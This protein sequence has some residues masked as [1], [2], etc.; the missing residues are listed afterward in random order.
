MAGPRTQKQIA[1]KYKGNLAYF[2]KPHF[3]RRLKFLVSL[4]AVLIGAAAIIWFQEH[5]SDAFYS[6][7]PISQ[8]HAS[9]KD[10]CRACHTQI[11]Q[12][13][14]KLGEPGRVATA[15]GETLQHGVP[16]SPLARATKRLLSGVSF[17][18]IDHACL[19]CHEHHDLHAPSAGGLTLREFRTELAQATTG[20]CSSCHREHAGSGRM[21]MP[22]AE[23]CAAC[24]NDPQRMENSLVRVPLPGKKVRNAAVL[25]DLGDGQIHFIAPPPDRQKPAPTF[26]SFENGHPPFEY[27]RPGLRDP[28]VLKYN[29][30]RH[31]AADIPLVNGK[32][33]DCNYCHKPAGDGTYYGKASY[34]QNCAAC[35]SL[36]IDPRNPELRVPHGDPALV[37]TFLRSLDYQYEQLGLKKGKRGAELQAF[38]AE[39][40]RELL[41]RSDTR[42]G[43]EFEQQVFFTGNPYQA[44]PG[45]VNAALF[46][47]CA[48][49]HEV[50]PDP[51]T[52][53]LG[54]PIITKPVMADRYLHRGAFTHQEHTHVACAGC[55]NASVSRDTADVLMPTQKSC[56]SCHTHEGTAP[57]DCFTCH[58][59]HA[60]AS[61]GQTLR[62]KEPHAHLRLK[63]AILSGR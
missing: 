2:R 44:Q 4:L 50:K 24:H 49:C 5:G 25:R 59:Y 9:F 17:T 20:S 23:F 55:H 16:G 12:R 31:E 21:E 38:A 61:V 57:N 39:Q 37:R 52:G 22:G 51:R 40:R 13:I 56:A 26:A 19:R 60:P 18:E 33:M 29:H 3:F 41:R 14:Q 35:H 45:V 7:G 30:A 32:K 28:N 1:E 27:E 58:S 47:G 34:T 15:A 63:D 10:D 11:D 53:S 54:T 36:Q 46:P 6:P 8:N 42:T 48:Y 43:E 62:A